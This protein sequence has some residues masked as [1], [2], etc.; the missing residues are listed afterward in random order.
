MKKEYKQT[1]MVWLGA[2]VIWIAAFLT[3]IVVG[4]VVKTVAPDLAGNS[5]FLILFSTLPIYV[6]GIP[7]SLVFFRRAE[8]APPT[9]KRSLPPLIF[10][11]VVAV[12]FA[13]S[14][15]GSV[16]GQG[17]NHVISSIT[18]EPTVDPVEEIT[19]GVPFFVN[20]LVVAVAAPIM[21]E[22]VY[23]KLVIDRLRRYGEIPAVLFS[24][25][26]FGATH[27]NFTQFFYAFFLGVV[28]GAVYCATG[29][30][31]YTIALHMIIN[32]FATV[33]TLFALTPA[34]LENLTAET[35][36]SS[37]PAIIWRL[38]QLA[39][40]LASIVATPFAFAWIIPRLRPASA[41]VDLPRDQSLR[42]ALLNPAL[43]LLVVLLAAM[44]ILSF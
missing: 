4:R 8:A 31:R 21:E 10:F 25:L 7:L 20:Y 13:L 2:S 44:F 26:L 14:I 34:D 12:C 40:Y 28:F 15:V 19:A 24:G 29:K 22:L 5:V 38:V 27:G 6:V 3:Q 23:R 37:L 30:L 43:W 35:L 32:G 18:G 42:V 16:I 1:S 41:S 33:S 9:E 36:F 39:I 17:V 11:A